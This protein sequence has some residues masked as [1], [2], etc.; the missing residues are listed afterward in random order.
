MLGG[1]TNGSIMS[2]TQ[3]LD[4]FPKIA[5][6][7]PPVSDLDSTRR[8]LANTVSISTCT[9]ASDDLNARAISQPSGQRCSL[10]IS[11]KI[12]HPI[13]L[14]VDQH[15]S[16]VTATPPCPVIDTQNP[17]RCDGFNRLSGGRCQRRS[18]TEPPL[19][20]IAG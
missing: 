12:N 10:T 20:W 18:K 14:K 15:G 8:T 7:V 6:Q 9:I 4:G 2:V 16:V 17:Q 11:V 1:T 13:R 19:V 5:E 3:G